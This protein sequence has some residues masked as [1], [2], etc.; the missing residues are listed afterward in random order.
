MTQQPIKLGGFKILKG[1]ARFSLVI[2][3]ESALTPALFLKSVAQKK[4]NLP[5]LTCVHSNGYWGINM[6]LESDKGLMLSLLIEEIAGKS[7]DLTS[8]FAVLS[9]FPHKNDPRILSRLINAL[10]SNSV[11][12]EAV[13]TSP[14]TISIV[15]QES[16]LNSAST[17]LFGPFSFSAYRTPEDWKLAQKG[18]E[19]IYKEIIATY[20]EKRPKV[21]GLEYHVNQHI[22]YINLEK[23]SSLSAELFGKDSSDNHRLT[24]A[25]SYP[26][27]SC[28][29]EILGICLSDVLQENDHPGIV[30]SM[31]GPHFGDRY[32]ISHEL[33][34]SL[35]KRNVDVRCLSCT[36]AS[37]TGVV[38]S[39]QLDQTI[40]GIK[41]CFDVPVVVQK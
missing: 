7:C 40:E 27:Q 18:K 32:G 39:S 9:I 30:F 11:R 35:E 33:L 21:Y 13:A 10:H 36:I 23:G 14:S 15:L 41:D 2:P 4:I 22:S 38:D 20:Q 26:A 1:M 6:L 25:A 37:I 24:F 5:Y 17:S 29:E 3:E 31:N 16:D 28:S 12:A 8:E 19:H 34:Y